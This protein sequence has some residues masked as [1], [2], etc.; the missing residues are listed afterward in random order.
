LHHGFGLLFVFAPTGG[1]HPQLAGNA[2]GGLTESTGDRL[3]PTDAAGLAG[4]EQE[5]RLKPVLR[6][7]LVAQH[8]PANAQH[9]G[10]MTPHESLK[11]RF[12]PAFGKLLQKLPI[13]LI[14]ADG[15][16]EYAAEASNRARQLS[17]CHASVQSSGVSF[18]TIMPDQCE[19]ARIFIR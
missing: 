10:T 17:H 8:P 13:T 3:A 18:F 4:Q 5:S 16:T 19:T 11:S 12:I 6:V 14:A 2:I 15:R 7:G 9:E 1:L